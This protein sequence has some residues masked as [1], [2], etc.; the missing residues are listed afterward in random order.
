MKLLRNILD[1][2]PDSLLTY[3][4][5]AVCIVSA[6]FFTSRFIEPGAPDVVRLAAGSKTGAYYQYAQK[7]AAYLKAHR[8]NLEIIETAGAL[9]NLELLEAGKVD[10]AFVQSG[11]SKKLPLTKVQA[12]GALYY[13]PLWVFTRKGS[14][15]E[16]IQDL[17]GKNISIGGV[18][19]GTRAVSEDI[20]EANNISRSNSRYFGYKMP[21]LF[22][23]LKTGKIEAAFIVGLYGASTVQKFL[24]EEDF[25]V[26]SFERALAYSKN[27]RAFAPITM[28]EGL[29][30]IGKDLPPKDIDL[31][32]PVAILAVHDDFYGALKS[33]F[34]SMMTE[35]HDKEGPFSDYGDF[36]S[37]GHIDLP[38]ASEAERYFEHGSNFLQKYLPFWLADLV[39]RLKI[40]L[41]P[42]IG[43]LLPLMKVA[44]PTYRWRIRYKIYRWYKDLKHLE[45]QG[46][47]SKNKAELD[48]LIKSLDDIDIEA[49]RTKVPLSYTDALYD[50]RLHIKLV[51][52]HLSELKG[53]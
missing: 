3:G 51:R 48:D 52:D 39:D 11:L 27:F 10:V 17:K 23:A 47:E 34:M 29:V 45:E 28:P 30:D 22:E 38:L 12:L 41:I 43:V 14:Q 44:P 36:P 9:E 46:M 21:Q 19:S 16:T 18:G 25:S 50:L 7:Y 4:L 40:M 13:E 42:L 15:I 26:L 37:R 33:L 49:K 6:F 5:I 32:S 2:I 53:A 31:V 1:K 20:L 8:V 35:T 24:N